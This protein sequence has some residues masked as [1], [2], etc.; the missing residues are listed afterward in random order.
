MWHWGTWFGG[1]LAELGKQLDSMILDIFCNLKDC[2][3]LRN[4]LS[5]YTLICC[6]LISEN[7]PHFLCQKWLQ[8]TYHHAETTW[9]IQIMVH[10]M[11]LAAN[12][13]VAVSGNKWPMHGFRRDP[14]DAAAWCGSSDSLVLKSTLDS[15]RDQDGHPCWLPQKILMM[16]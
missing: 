14:T 13:T 15:Q 12:Y 16:F 1:D 7:I 11:H 10:E 9:A 3:L 8:M 6:L 5:Y 2:M 4:I